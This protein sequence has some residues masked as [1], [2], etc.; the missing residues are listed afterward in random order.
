M[1]TFVQGARAMTAACVSVVTFFGTSTT[2]TADPADTQANNDKLFAELSGGYTPADCKAGKQYPEDPFLARLGCG[3]NS[4]PG[5]PNAATYSLYGNI[6][7]LNKTFDLYGPSIPCPGPTAWPGGQVKC[8]HGLY[9]Q[10]SQ[11]MLTWTKDADLVVVNAVGA[12]LPSLYAWW[13][14]AR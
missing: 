10:Q 4:R 1:F 6:A 2:A 3:R 9:P 13:L 8:G 14:T 12:D 11:S 5:G 7:D